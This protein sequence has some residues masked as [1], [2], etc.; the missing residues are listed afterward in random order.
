M[1]KVKHTA[2]SRGLANHGWLK[3]NHSFSFANYYNAERMNF[4][5]LRVLNDDIVQPKMGFGTHPHQNMDYIYSF[6]R[7]IISQRQHE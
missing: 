3:S 7:N 6:K 1:H 2:N 5:A 4:G